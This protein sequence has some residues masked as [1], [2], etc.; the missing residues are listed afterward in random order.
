V[1]VSSQFLPDHI[2]LICHSD[3]L[4]LN[5]G[6]D[7]WQRA[8][9]ASAYAAAAALGTNFKLFMSFDFTSSL[10]CNIGDIRDRVNQFAGHPN[11]FRVNEKPMI[12]SYE[13]ACSG[14]DWWSSLK[15]QTNGYLM[16]FISGLEGSFN[17]WQS[18][19]SWYWYAD[20]SYYLS[21]T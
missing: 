6:G 10:A 20:P 17:N 8:Q 9:V 3:A 4:A 16:P 7:G 15:A 5:I 11:Q 18:L 13:G 2:K 19:D 14:N 1:W 12:S 21:F